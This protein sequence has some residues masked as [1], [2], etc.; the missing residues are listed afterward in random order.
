MLSHEVIYD[1]F[2]A[3]G[4][5]VEA[6]EV[7]IESCLF[8]VEVIIVAYMCKARCHVVVQS[9]FVLVGVPE[10]AIPCRLENGD[11]RWKFVPFFLNVAMMSCIKNVLKRLG[12]DRCW[13]HYIMEGIDQAVIYKMLDA[14]IGVFLV[15]VY[16]TMSL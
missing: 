7:A 10:G 5:F 1:E 15:S 6:D 9:H 16:R 14:R 12:R 3:F 11:N 2:L 8:C 13:R 4:R